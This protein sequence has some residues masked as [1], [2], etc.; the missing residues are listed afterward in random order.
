MQTDG[1]GWLFAPVGVADGPLPAHYEPPESPVRNPLYAQQNNPGRKHLSTPSNPMNPSFSEVFPYVFTTYRLTEHHTAGAMSRTLPYLTELQP[2]P[3]CEVSPRLAA[4]RGLEHGEW[5]TIVTARTAIEARVLVTERLRSLR[6]GEQWV[7]QVGLPYHWGRNGITTGDSPNDLV[8]V[9]MDPNVS[10]QDKV[11][12]CDIRPGRR[13]RGP[14]LTAYVEDYRRRA[15]VGPEDLA[16]QPHRRRHP[17][18][19]RLSE[20]LSPESLWGRLDDVSGDAGLR[21]PPRRGWASS[22]TPRCASAARPARW[23]A[24]SGT[25]SPTT[26]TMLTGMS[27]DNTQQLGA[28]TWRHVAFVEKTRALEVEAGTGGDRPRH[29]RQ[30]PAGCARSRCRTVR[31]RRTESGDS[32]LRWLMSSDVCKHCTH[33]A[34]LD[35]CPTGSLFRT[36]FGTVVVQEDICNGCGYCVP[37]CPYGVIDQR[38]HDGRAFK[39]TLCYD[40]LKEGQTPACAQACPTESIQYGEVD[41]LR[42]RA[43]ARVEE[44]HDQGRR[45]GPALRR[46][47]RRRG[48]RGRGV[49]PA[50]RRA[51]GLRPAARPDRD[52][53]RPGRDVAP[54]RSGR[55][56]PSPVSAPPRSWV[57][58]SPGG[59][60]GEPGRAVDGAGA[61]LRVLLRPSDPQGTDLEDPRRP[62]L[63]VDRRGRRW[64]GAARRG[65]RAERSARVSSAS[66]GSAAAGGAVVGTVALVHDLGRPERFLNMLRVFK[67]TSPLSVGSYILAPFSSFAGAAAASH[68]TGVAPRLGPAGRPGRGRLRAAAGHLH[69]R[70]VRQHRDPGL[71]RGAPRAAVRLR[72]LRGG[73]GRWH[74]DAARSRRRDRARGADGGRGRGRRAGCQPSDGAAARACSPSP[75]RRGWRVGSRSC[76]G[77]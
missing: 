49:L 24:R 51:G 69:R 34:C 20:F 61:D 38:K 64:L 29:A 56:S 9:T 39:C 11:G 45:R 6:L 53:P 77:R 8:N 1:K 57:G 7:E 58:R 76:R 66:P 55:P 42:E 44:L 41:E 32:G 31:T 46:R 27:Y 25:R 2:E 74:R 73:R 47:P 15:G 26:A 4:E 50:P 43:A 33:A 40:R 17:D 67:P 14:A 62:D 16:E 70:P 5:V 21:G 75:T 63:P 48:R 65:C 68:V 35:V 52:D 3:F 60:A 36:E 37:A 28:S 19:S 59:R 23:R 18:V 13:P 22:P 10:I 54:R 72:R 30:R 12:T 71:A